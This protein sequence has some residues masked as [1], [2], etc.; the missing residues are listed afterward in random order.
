MLAYLVTFNPRPRALIM[1]DDTSEA[2]IHHA[3]PVRA[4]GLYT[5]GGLDWTG[6]DWTEILVF[7]RYALAVQSRV[8]YR[9]ATDVLS[10]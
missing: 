10:R 9:E 5:I 4:I 2:T 8:R 6:L 1:A 7:S 3:F